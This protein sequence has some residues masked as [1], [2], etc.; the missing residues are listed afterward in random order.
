MVVKDMVKEM[1]TMSELRAL[2]EAEVRK[3]PEFRAVTPQSPY[4]HEPDDNG[5]NWNLYYWSGPEPLVDKAK[6]C[7]APA[8]RE[9][10]EHY[11]GKQDL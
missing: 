7:I 9:L 6:R 2:I 4:L 1:R 10:R 5:S 3:Y 8:L 11:L